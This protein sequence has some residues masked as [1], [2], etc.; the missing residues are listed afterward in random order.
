LAPGSSGLFYGWWMVAVAFLAQGLSAG[1]TTYLFGLF[2]KPMAEE[3][4]TERGP[5]SLG[6]SLLS[7]SMGV[8]SPFLG[9][10]LDRR[11]IR[12]VM[13]GGALAIGVGFVLIAAAPSLWL[14][15]L[16]FTTLTAFGSIATGPLSASKLVANWFEAT[17]GRALGVASTGTSAG[18]AVLPP[19]AA[20]A[21]AAWGWRG[22]L[23]ALGAAIA[24][25][26]VPL[27]WLL[28]RN[29]PE[30]HGLLPDGAT[31][32]LAQAALRRRRSARAP[33]PAR[34]PQLLGDRPAV[35]LSFVI[36]GGLLVTLHP[37]DRSRHR[38]RPAVFL[39]TILSLTGI[40]GKLA[41]ERR[42]PPSKRILMAVAMAM[43]VVFLLVLLGEPGYPMLAAG[44]AF[45]G[46]ALGGFLPIWGALIAECWGRESFARV[47]GLMGP[48]MTPLTMSALAL[49]GFVYDRTGSY[50]LAFQVFLGTFA[51]AAGC[52]ALLRSPARRAH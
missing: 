27:I 39:F 42:R 19:L 32:S 18:G 51:V 40:C 31:P 25:L 10:A 38:R 30:D 35:G 26:A 44:C 7:L 5:I 4:G 46:L 13:A 28:V 15:G 48:L 34:R 52:L 24:V 6:M 14:V 17:R 3:F 8:M 23:A 29:R 16:V 37:Y 21:I 50:G 41:S 22:A 2:V 47:M 49:P 12:G 11:P 1:S 45:A 43:S 36:L 20:A 9:S 33:R